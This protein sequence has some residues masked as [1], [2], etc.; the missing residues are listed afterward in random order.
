MDLGAVVAVVVALVGPVEW[1]EAVVV[2][3]RQL[4]ALVVVRAV[5]AVGLVGLV[6]LVELA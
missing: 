6:D 1:E 5:A 3:A 4:H 2:P